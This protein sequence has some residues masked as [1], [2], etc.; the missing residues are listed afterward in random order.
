M[1]RPSVTQLPM[2]KPSLAD[3]RIAR[4]TKKIGNFTTRLLPKSTTKTLIIP[5]ISSKSLNKKLIKL[6]PQQWLSPSQSPS[7]IL[8]F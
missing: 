8:D 5:N 3:L 1:N 7:P 6:Y 2:K 4:Q